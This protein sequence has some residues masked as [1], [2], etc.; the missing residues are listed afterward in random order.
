MPEYVSPA[1][2]LNQ[3][4]L[5]GI[6][7]FGNLGINLS[8]MAENRRQFDETKKAGAAKATMEQQQHEQKMLVDIIEKAATFKTPAQSKNFL[9]QAYKSI[10]RNDLAAEAEKINLDL[11]PQ[12][13]Q[14]MEMFKR[15]EIP[16]AM[17][18][19]KA[20]GMTESETKAL[21]EEVKY[22]QE[23]AGLQRSIDTAY[24]IKPS[25]Y[26][27]MPEQRLLPTIT[28]ALPPTEPFNANILLGSKYNLNN[29]NTELNA[30]IPAH[31]LFNQRAVPLTQ[32]QRTAREIG[33]SG[34]IDIMKK[35]IDEKM[36]GEKPTYH[37]GTTAVKAPDGKYKLPIYVNG[38]LT[39]YS[40]EV[41]PSETETNREFSQAKD[42][43]N[44][45]I[46]MAG[47]ATGNS[48]LMN[49]TLSDLE[50]SPNR[51]SEVKE[52][53]SSEDGIP[54]RK[55]FDNAWQT[56]GVSIPTEKAPK[57]IP[58][59]PTGWK[60]QKENKLPI[61]S[62]PST[63]GIK[64]NDTAINPQTGERIIYKGGVWQNLK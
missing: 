8:N 15:G 51:Y 13:E 49:L 32:E 30:T 43:I 34:N 21:F 39:G 60:E 27:Q 63:G 23:K 24:D 19:A 11:M 6:Q 17:Q 31:G 9:I 50:N 37:Y 28:G 59:K 56:L 57:D 42:K 26:T 16:N 38:K 46:K 41:K 36:K 12:Y 7:T 1:G 2:A 29:V 61:K 14:I 52:W 4:L 18:S 62:S 44:E 40:D 5:Q 25:T 54:F 53:L 20:I 33:A 55:I 45:I 47:K 35:A 10:R 64:E 3:G 22:Q 48:F 58:K